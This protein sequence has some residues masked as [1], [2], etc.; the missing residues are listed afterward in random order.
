MNV[1]ME[2]LLA[3]WNQSAF[4]KCAVFNYERQKQLAARNHDPFFRAH[5]REA[6]ERAQKQ[7][8]C[9]GD[10]DRGWVATLD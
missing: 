7:P 2:E 1:T 9:L 4:R 5:W 10:N 8:F 6:L 3:A